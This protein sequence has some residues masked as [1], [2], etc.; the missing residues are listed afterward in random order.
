MIYFVIGFFLVILA[1][2][3]LKK[4]NNPYQDKSKTCSICNGHG[5]LACGGSGYERKNPEGL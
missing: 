3:L 5:C 4:K 1:F 2:K